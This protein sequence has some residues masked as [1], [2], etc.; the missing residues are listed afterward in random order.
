MIRTTTTTD[1]EEPEVA[2]RNSTSRAALSALSARSKLHRECTTIDGITYKIASC[3]EEREAAFRLVYDAYT[4]GGLIDSNPYEM[5]VTPFHLV[6]TTDVFIARHEG[7]V[8]YTLTLVSDDF[9]GLPM[10]S[11]YASEIDE[12]RK[13]GCYLAEVSCLASRQDYFSRSRMLDVFVQLLGLTCQYCRRNDIDRLLIAIHPRHSRFYRRL[14]GVE[15]IGEV[16]QYAC[17]RDHP[18]VACEHDFVRMDQER[19][20]MYDRIYGHLFHRAELLRQPM[21]DDDREYFR[22]ASKFCLSNLPAFAA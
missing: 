2:I 13:N 7:N 18:A 4:Q 10:Q 9:A 22:P 8:V 11:I 17:V 12:R 20:P 21:L 1:R 3:R 6:A 16:K 5:R 14:L 15:Q 19:Y